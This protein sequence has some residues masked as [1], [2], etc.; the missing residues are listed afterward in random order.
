MK[1]LHFITQAKGGVGKSLLMYL[2]ALKHYQN[3]NYLFIDLDA[4][5][6]TSQRQLQFVSPKQFRGVS[7]LDE[8]AVLVRDNLVEYLELISTSPFSEIYVDMGAPESEQLP[9]LIEFDLPL[10]EFAEELGLEIQ[11]HVVVAGAGAYSPSV[12]FL[13]KMIDVAGEFKITVWQNLSSFR[14]FAELSKELKENCQLMQ[15]PFRQ[16]GDFEVGS[17]LGAKILSGT[18][19]G[20][21][22]EEYET[23]PRL[24]LKRELHFNISHD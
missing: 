18:R 13:K 1:R 10:R 20:L 2:L 14:K 3:P 5:S 9:A 7:L 6:F 16:F 24:R 4:S 21:S 8:R 12:E 22:L 17:Y 19:R 11:F 15:L 23:G